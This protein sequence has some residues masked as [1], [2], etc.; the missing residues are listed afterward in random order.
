MTKLKRTNN[1][2]KIIKI[3]LSDGTI[4]QRYETSRERLIKEIQK[5]EKRNKREVSRKNT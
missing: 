1:M 5:N 4:I 2:P 3:K